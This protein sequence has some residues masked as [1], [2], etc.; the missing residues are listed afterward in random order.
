[1]L[2]MS[3]QEENPI[4]FYYLCISISHNSL[5]CFK[6]YSNSKHIVKTGC[7]KRKG[8]SKKIKYSEVGIYERKQENAL[9]TKKVI[10]KKKEEKKEN[11]LLTKKATKKKRKKNDNGQGKN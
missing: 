1:M 9:S 2:E 7:N 6:S 5:S 10:K 3:I 8:G 4:E 11:M